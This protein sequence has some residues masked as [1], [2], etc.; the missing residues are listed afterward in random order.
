MIPDFKG[1]PLVVQPDDS[2][3]DD[4]YGHER[5]QSNPQALPRKERR[6]AAG[7]CER[8]RTG[9]NVV[10]NRVAQVRFLSGHRII[11]HSRHTTAGADR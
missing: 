5:T 2:F 6:A 3:D 9:G 10:L 11:Q 4:A 8:T 7:M 1:K